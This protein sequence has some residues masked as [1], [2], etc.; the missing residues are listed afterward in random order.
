MPID[1][2]LL[3]TLAG[4]SYDVNSVAFSRDSKLL[5]SGGGDG[6][7]RF[8]GV[9]TQQ[10]LHVAQHGDWVNTV[11]FAPSGQA[12]ASGARDGSIKVWSVDTAQAFGSIQAHPQNVASAMFSPDGRRLISG[13]GD[14]HVRI[15]N[16]REKKIERDVEAHSG[17]I[18]RVAISSLG[19]R[20]LSTGGDKSA[21]IWSMETGVRLA[22]LSG[23]EDDVLYGDFSPDDR[24]VATACKDGNVMLWQPETGDPLF[25]FRA[26]EGAANSVTFSVDGLHIVTSGADHVIRVWAVEDGSLA[27]ELTGHQDYVSTATFSRDGKFMASCGGD[28]T[29]KIWQVTDRSAYSAS[30]LD[31]GLE[32]EH[33]GAERTSPAYSSVYAAGKTIATTVTKG[34][35]KVAMMQSGGDKFA[36]AVGENQ[37]P[38]MSVGSDELTVYNGV[39][40]PQLRLNLATMSVTF[41]RTDGGAAPWETDRQDSSTGSLDP[42]FENNAGRSFASSGGMELEIERGDGLGGGGNRYQAFE[43]HGEALARE[44]LGSSG[45]YVRFVRFDSNTLYVLLDANEDPTAVFRGDNL[46]I[47]DASKK[48]VFRLHLRSLEPVIVRRGGAEGPAAPEPEIVRDPMVVMGLSEMDA[49]SDEPRIHKVL[50]KAVWGKAS[51]IHIPSG[52]PIQMRRNGQ[53]EVAQDRSYQPSEIESMVYQILTP[54]QLERFKESNDLDFSYEIPGVARFR[55]NVLR[56]HRGIDATFRIIPDTIPSLEALGLP[57][58][59]APLTKHHNGLVLITGPAGQGKSTTIAALVDLINSEKPLHIITVEDPIEFIHPIKRAVVNQR[60]VGKHTRSFANALRAALREDPDVIIVGELRD[61]ETISLAITASETGHLVF[62]SLMTAS[63]SQTIDRVLDSFPAS[64][65][66]QIRTMVSESLRGVVSQ[67]LV[68]LA[69]G[70]GRALACEV[71]LGT[72]AVGNLIREKKTFQIASIMQTG[73]NLGMQRMDDSLFEMFQAGRITA[74]MAMV[75][76]QDPKAMEPRLKPRPSGADAVPPPQPGGLRR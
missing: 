42:N 11:C 53:L 35:L 21:H 63:A 24:L 8:W 59:V 15:F 62:G 38:V 69:N 17:W 40:V 10:E 48:P 46:D 60:E 39:S 3:K 55:A 49:S 18:W 20:L 19:D 76:S 71:L 33:E 52:A 25:A 58:S 28:G 29:V 54:L 2:N 51:D 50:T 30:G 67:Q 16:L 70:E 61:L 26:H 6:T 74:D 36:F 72:P 47:R 1:F 57:P 12:V 4:H 32:I 31:P 44:R 14:G 23:H 41:D 27:R 7:V 66:S 34:G 5:V 9:S 13:G 56:Q 64:Q 45:R 75:Y 22:T 65:Q 68:P 37:R 73:R 43:K